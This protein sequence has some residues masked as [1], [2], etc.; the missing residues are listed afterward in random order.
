M[1]ISIVQGKPI[2]RFV[3]RFADANSA[4][5]KAKL[6][7]FG[8]HTSQYDWQ[9]TAEANT[10]LIQ[11]FYAFGP[12]LH[13]KSYRR[14]TCSVSN[15]ISEKEH[16]ALNRLYG[17]ATGFVNMLSY[18]RWRAFETWE[19]NAIGIRT[20][21]PYAY[22]VQPQ[23]AGAEEHAPKEANRPEYQLVLVQSLERV[24][25]IRKHNVLSIY[26]ICTVGSFRESPSSESISSHDRK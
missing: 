22:D 17:E 6:S 16:H 2:E 3:G 26:V 24:S 11:D 25:R 20:H 21:L 18:A 19:K 23:R 5:G 15:D 8:F 13:Q 7:H 9:Q 14:A 12:S 1:D 10:S 4:I